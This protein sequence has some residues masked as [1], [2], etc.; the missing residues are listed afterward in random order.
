MLIAEDLLILLT[1]DDSGRLTAPGE[2]VDVG[3]AGANLLDLTLMNKVDLS[4]EGDQGKPGRIVVR[5]GSPT[6]DAVLDAALEVLRAHQ[7]RK[8]AAVLSP[9]AKHVR[10]T[11]YARLVED[12]LVREAAGHVMGVFPTHRWPVLDATHEAEVRRLLTGALVEGTDPDARTAALIALLH[13]L[14]CEQKVVEPGRHGMS[15]RELKA[16][17]EAVTKGDWASEAVKTAIDQMTLA[18]VAAAASVVVLPGGSN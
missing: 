18:V 1:D 4:R 2:Q 6:G 9:L 15:K 3:L 13:A 5:D 11:V 10:R 12:G 14:D 16:R 8:P 17:A 7:G